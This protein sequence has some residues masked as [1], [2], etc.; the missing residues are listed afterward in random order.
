MHGVQIRVAESRDCQDLSFIYNQYL[1]KST[2]DLVEKSADDFIQFIHQKK[3]RNEELLVL[4]EQDQILGWGIIKRYSERLGYQFAAET[5][6]YL[7]PQFI[8]KGLGSLL[9]KKILETCRKMGY[10][11]LVAKVIARNVKSIEYNLKL[12][13]RICGLQKRIGYVNGRWE[14]IVLM[15]MHLD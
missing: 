5:S 11:Y 13:Y 4:T 15:E 10:R 14:D 8:G 9:K 2:F 7:H 3:L 12:G 1:G 6:I